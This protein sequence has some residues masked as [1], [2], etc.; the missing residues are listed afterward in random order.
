M[1]KRSAITTAGGITGALVA[2]LAAIALALGGV[3]AANAGDEGTLT[4]T[5][6]V[7]TTAPHATSSTAGPVAASSPTATATSTGSDDPTQHDANDD[8]GL[9]N[10]ANDDDG[11]ENEAGTHDASDDGPDSG[12]GS[13]NEGGSGDD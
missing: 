10:E 3:S 9:E 8:D 7:Q 5:A 13:M 11:L 4:P 1:T 12:S 6:N 2:S